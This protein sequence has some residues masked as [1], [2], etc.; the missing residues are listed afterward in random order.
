MTTERFELLEQLGRGGMGVVW[1]ARDTATGDVV[2][3][4][5]LHHMLAEDPDYVARF[6]REVEVAQRIDSP[7]VVKVSG[8]GRR[9]GVPYM[10]ME[11]VEGQ[12]LRDLVKARGKLPWEE[13]RDIARQVAAGLAAAH[14]AGV[15]H[16][17]VKPSNI[18]ITPDGTAKLADFG[19]ARALDLTRLTGSSTM[20]GTPLYM[21]PEGQKDE[22]ADLYSLGCVLYEMLAGVPPFEGDSQQEI[23]RKHDREEPDLGKL[24]PV[25]R[26]IVGE[27]LAK[28]PGRR[29]AS[30]ARAA[31]VLGGGGSGG[32]PQVTPAVIAW[33]P[34]PR[35]GR[36]RR[37]VL[38][39]AFGTLASA[40]AL[41][42]VFL[43]P[44][45][46]STPSSPPP[47]TAASATAPPAG[48]TSTSTYAATSMPTLTDAPSR[49][50][51]P[52][53]PT[54][55]PIPP[56]PTPVPAV[57][58]VP[59]VE[60]AVSPVNR[61]GAQVLFLCAYDF[62][63]DLQSFVIWNTGSNPGGSE[64]T[65]IL[66]ATEA[67]PFVW[68]VAKGGSGGLSNPDFVSESGCHAIPGAI[69]WTSS[70][71]IGCRRDIIP[72]GYSMRLGVRAVD[73]TGLSS[74]P[75]FVDITCVPT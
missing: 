66:G 10:A 39:A 5:L 36:I 22:R 20:L 4:K 40:M 14:A 37:D 2:A 55:A 60:R 51:T 72:D 23:W 7:N 26:T 15:I 74:E 31:V 59:V 11:Y 64:S 16:R 54:P 67:V 68:P 62:D 33:S 13:A 25:A 52:V 61:G 42:A 28:E 35:R 9:E 38:F 44:D 48:L 49:T 58:R 27:L 73:D 43:S 18:L 8:Y 34:E 46:G 41:G 63:G 29:M 50:P 30:A 47:T 19:I 65:F 1:K 32:V 17:D 56:T 24:P 71:S 21:A 6:Q 57:E 3:L 70:F 12:S 45:C 69:V 75:T 53:P